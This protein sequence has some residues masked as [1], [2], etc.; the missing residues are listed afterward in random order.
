M[1]RLGSKTEG[2][3]PHVCVSLRLINGPQGAPQPVGQ[4]SYAYFQSIPE[5]A[6]EMVFKVS[7]ESKGAD[8]QY[9]NKT[10]LDILLNPSTGKVLTQLKR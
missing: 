10:K 8:D 5:T 7:I 6:H 1:L 3:V 4:V 2:A 9:R